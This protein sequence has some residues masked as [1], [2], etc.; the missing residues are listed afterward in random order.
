MWAR[1]ISSENSR[2]SKGR[3]LTS[4]MKFSS[5]PSSRPTL[6][7][8]DS[9]EAA[10]ADQPPAAV[11]VGARGVASAARHC[12]MELKSTTSFFPPWCTELYLTALLPR[13][14]LCERGT[15]GKGSEMCVA[16]QPI[17]RWRQQLPD[18]GLSRNYAAC[19]AGPGPRS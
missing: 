10:P 6:R 2:I 19:V 7:R 16:P 11:H 5:T 15:A 3:L 17:A 4:S 8:T 14:Y 1:A 9:P 13:R 12:V 18:C